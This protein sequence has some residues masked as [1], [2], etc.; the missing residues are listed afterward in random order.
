MSE[1]DVEVYGFYVREGDGLLVIEVV[2]VKESLEGDTV[3]IE[4]A[5]A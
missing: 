5:K 3:K 2:D 1:K 4:I